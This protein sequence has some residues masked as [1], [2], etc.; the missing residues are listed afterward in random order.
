M[1]GADIMLELQSSGVTIEDM[2]SKGLSDAVG[3]LFTDSV[4]VP[5]A[6][7][8][9]TSVGQDIQPVPAKWVPE[10]PIED[11]GIFF[12]A[13]EEDA[14]AHH[15]AAEGSPSEHGWN[16]D[17]FFEGAIS[18]LGLV[19]SLLAKLVEND[20]DIIRKYGASVA[21]LSKAK[22]VVKNELKDYDNSF[23]KEYGREPSRADKEPMRL[24][25]T[26][27]RKIRDI[28][29]RIETTTKVP[30][31]RSPQVAASQLRA[32]LERAATEER[33]EALMVEKQQLRTILHEYQTKFM[34]EQG[35]RIK[36]HRDIVAI[37]R[38]Y[39]QYKQAKEEI[40]K[41]EAQ[42]GRASSSSKKQSGSDFFL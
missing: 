7:V 34:Q 9:V 13:H 32:N 12:E 41:L 42:L 33:L 35:R 14:E 10:V 2:L 20:D 3:C 25:Y 5:F 11:E 17:A 40:A 15:T 6:N 22:K 8:K 23:K 31:V 28:I 18:R 30:P 1:S 29:V 38:E 16:G 39:R 27:Y 24:L 36:Y 37:D 26:L 4:P 19:S 21:D